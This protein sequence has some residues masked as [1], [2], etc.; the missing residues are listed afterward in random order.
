MTQEAANCT[1]EGVLDVA[2]ESLMAPDDME[3]ALRDLLT[4]SG[5]PQPDSRGKLVRCVLQSL[6]LEYAWRMDRLAELTGK[7]AD[8]LYMVGGGIAN[9]LLCQFTADAC[10]RS[11]YAGA[12]ECTALGNALIQAA[13]LGVVADGAEIRR[14]MKNSVEVA[15]F[16]PRESDV[17]Q[18]RRETYENI[19]TP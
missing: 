15:T 13:G 8:A 9:T 12:G 2:D 14:I 11:V 18:Q 5:Q 1:F 19:R 6:A 3:G 17:W 16:S 4:R 7:Q 10:G